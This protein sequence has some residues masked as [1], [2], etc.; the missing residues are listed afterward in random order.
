MNVLFN[1]NIQIQYD[2]NYP[3]CDYDKMFT[4]SWNQ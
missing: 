2:T 1:L 4:G 3:G